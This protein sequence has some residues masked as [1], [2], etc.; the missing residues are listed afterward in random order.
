MSDST[1]APILARMRESAIAADADLLGC[2]PEEIAALEHRYRVTLPAA[3]RQYLEVMG[4]RSGRLFTSDHAAVF[5]RYVLPMTDDFM[6]EVQQPDSF[7]LPAKSLLIACRLG[8]QFSFI[9][10]AE[11]DDSPVWYFNAWDWKI[12]RIHDS[13]LAWLQAWCDEA[14]RA[15]ASGYFETNPAGTAP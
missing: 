2:K 3:Y 1:L 5:Y 13:V 6:N 8:E 11:R 7:E 4:H 14:E 15:I 9:S 12:V 10:C